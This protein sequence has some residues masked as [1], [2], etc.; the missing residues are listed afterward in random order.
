MSS[1]QTMHLDND[2][3]ELLALGEAFDP[4][5]LRQMEDHLDSCVDCRKRLDEIRSF[6]T[7][8]E[9]EYQ[10]LEH[11]KV[12]NPPAA[13]ALRKPVDPPLPIYEHFVTA[14]RSSYG[15]LERLSAFRHSHPVA[16]G[17]GGF[18]LVGALGLVLFSLFNFDTHVNPAYVSLDASRLSMDVY[19][20]EDRRIWSKP[21]W[22]S[23]EAIQIALDHREQST[24]VVDIDRD[25]TNEI[26][27][28]NK[29]TSVGPDPL[30]SVVTIFNAD[31]S[32]RSQRSLGSI[33]SF[34]GSK[35]DTTF[36]AKGLFVM[37]GTDTSETEIYVC[38]ENRRSPF[39][40]VR[41][42]DS[43]NELGTYW[44]YG[45]LH[46]PREISIAGAQK[47][48]LLWGVDDG[49]REQGL[50]PSTLVALEPSRIVGETEASSTPGF[51]F[52]VSR[53]E[54]AILLFPDPDLVVARKATSSFQRVES[55][56]QVSIHVVQVF[57]TT[58]RLLPG[59][60]FILGRDL[61]VV[62]VKPVSGYEILHREVMSSSVT[63]RT[64]G[65]EYFRDLGEG[66][67]YWNGRNWVNTPAMVAP[68]GLL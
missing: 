59:I 45:H 30:S 64:L 44:H 42:D 9:E 62:Q 33:V 67:L 3:L 15:L 6:Y 34:R 36:D 7:A 66:V 57:Q 60:E 17:L 43:L 48:L 5:V 11:R 53:A 10:D 13:L 26:V 41:L 23:P 63:T 27:T 8:A 22:I 68:A 61:S 46:G 29:L 58:E 21:I 49:A 4:R 38:L 20:K 55:V 25:G 16:T 35:S 1:A 24:Q 40:L 50:S 19:D 54:I 18:A 51:G 2:K 12:F 31:G 47:A 32:L 28:T 14:R 52:P 39:A 65:P 56:T 37:A